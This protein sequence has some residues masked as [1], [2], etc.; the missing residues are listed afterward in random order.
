VFI[1]KEQ[2]WL[3]SNIGSFGSAPNVIMAKRAHYQAQYELRPDPF[4][5]RDVPRLLDESRAAV[6]KLINA[7]VQSVVFVS[8]STEGINTV[9]KNLRWNEDGK[10]VMIGFNTMYDACARA[11]DFVVDYFKGKVGVTEIALTYPLEDDEIIA[12]FKDRVKQV[13]GQGKRARLALFDVV[14]SNPG[15][16]FPWETM[17]SVCREL[18]IISLVDGAQSIGMVHLDMT[19]TSPDFLVSSCHKW[20]HVPR[21]CAVFHVPERNQHLIPSSLG[22]SRGYAPQNDSREGRTQPMPDDGTGKNHFVRNFEWTGTR[23]DSPLLCVKDAI[24]WRRDVLGGEDRIIAYLRDLNLRG[25]RHIAE[26]LG[27]TYLQNK[28]GTLTNC[29]MGNVALP[30][31]VGEEGKGRAPKGQAVL[32]KEDALKAFNWMQDKMF[33]EYRTFMALWVRWGRF[34]VRI[35]AQ[36]YLELDDYD[37]ASVVLGEL[38]QRVAKGEFKE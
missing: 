18:G 14:S 37:W 16:L 21:G 2:W 15:V 22:T 7:P 3:K 10:D 9:L 28:S 30:L 36:V 13:E 33:D 24:A 12:L 5:R 38:V 1:L 11:G 27:T 29:G 6:A 31:W 4:I 19:A 34:W 17:V 8:N 23:D 20:L 25:I 32:S 26:K 35:S